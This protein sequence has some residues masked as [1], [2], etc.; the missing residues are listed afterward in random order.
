MKIFNFINRHRSIDIIFL[1]LLNIFCHRGWFMPGIIEYGDW[2]Y[3]PKDFLVD[4]F[5]L[6]FCWTSRF[7]AGPNFMLYNWPL[8]WLMGLVAN[9]GFDFGVA[10]RVVYFFPYI[11]IS[12]VGIG[13][14]NFL[15]I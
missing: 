11:I 4:S 3:L 10:E 7:F 15:N 14:L 9:L 2:S 6:P 12:V 13:F 8:K 1:L 5:T